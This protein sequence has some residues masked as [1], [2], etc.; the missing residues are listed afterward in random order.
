MLK[1]G[2]S[3]LSLLCHKALTVSFLSAA[4]A[5]SEK[6]TR[7]RCAKKAFEINFDEDIDFKAHFR[8]TKVCA[9]FLP[10]PAFSFAGSVCLGTVI[11]KQLASCSCE[12]GSVNP[13]LPM[14]LGA[15]SSDSMSHYK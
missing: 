9:G 13:T 6:E 1:L 10:L 3:C 4:D 11:C 12:T 14:F 2:V 5:D 7:K 15:G 8:K